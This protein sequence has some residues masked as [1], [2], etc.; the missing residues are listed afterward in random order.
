MKNRVVGFLVDA[1]QLYG[2]KVICHSWRV[3]CISV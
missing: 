1:I 3:G 2:Q